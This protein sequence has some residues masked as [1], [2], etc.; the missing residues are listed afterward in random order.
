MLEL[1]GWDGWGPEPPTGP[2]PTFPI[3]GIA[4]AWGGVGRMGRADGAGL[5]TALSF[6]FV[7]NA[8]GS[9]AGN[10]H[11]NVVLLRLPEWH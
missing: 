3:C 10:K 8:L 11:I 7:Q 9:Q 2:S 6:V 4:C 1:G 5:G